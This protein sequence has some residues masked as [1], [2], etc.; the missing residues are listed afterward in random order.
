MGEQPREVG[1]LLRNLRLLILG[2]WGVYPI[3]YLAPVLGISG[4]GSMVGLQ[5][6]YTVADITAKAGM[7]LM[8]YAIAREKT[9]AAG[10]LESPSGAAIPA[11]A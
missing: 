1:V 11:A 7:G 4:A 9:R 3:A 6:G 8:I 10:G 5:V 2:T